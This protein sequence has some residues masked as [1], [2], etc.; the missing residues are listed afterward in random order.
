MAFKREIA[1]ALAIW[2]TWVRQDDGG[3]SSYRHTT[4]A[5]GRLQLSTFDRINLD[6]S[7]N[8]HAINRYIASRAEKLTMKGWLRRETIQRIQKALTNGA[9]GTFL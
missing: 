1:P 8:G 9:Q 6:Q 3:H 7:L 4:I 2:W 5:N